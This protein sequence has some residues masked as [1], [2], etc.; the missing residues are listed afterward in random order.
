MLNFIRFLHDV[1]IY[2]T[3]RTAKFLYTHEFLHLI[4]AWKKYTWT[5][6]LNSPNLNLLKILAT[7]KTFW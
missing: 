1:P 3:V 2:M 4:I 5:S 7:H 6:T